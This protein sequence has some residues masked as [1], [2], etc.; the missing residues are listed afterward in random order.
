MLSYQ[1]NLT[2]NTLV[3]GLGRSGLASLDYYSELKK[4]G[5]NDV[6][7]FAYD[8]SFAKDEHKFNDLVASYPRIKLIKNK[9]EIPF[10]A[11]DECVASPGI[12]DEHSVITRFVD[13]EKPV[14]CDIEI[15]ARANTL[16]VVA[17]T[18]TNGKS[19]VVSWLADVLNR[20]GYKT[21]LAGNIGNPILSNYSF[22]Q[23]SKFDYVVLELSSF[24]L[25]RTQSL[26]NHVALIL[27]ITPDHMDRY[28]SIDD[29]KAAKEEIYSN[30]KC[31]V[32]N[33]DAED[34]STPKF[35]E[36][37]IN[38]S[39]D[40]EADFSSESINEEVY[41]LRGDQKL[42][43]Q[44]ALQLVGKHNL[45]NALAVLACCTALGIDAIDAARELVHFR[46]LPHRVE[47]LGRYKG[48]H[49]I[50]DSKATN[51]DATIAALSGLDGPIVLILGG[52]A[53]A[54]DL[55][56]L[57]KS[58]QAK[59]KKVIAYGKD[60]HRFVSL[61][62]H[63]VSVTEVNAF[64]DAVELATESAAKDDTVLL[65]PACSSLD[66]FKNYE[67]RGEEFRRLVGQLGVA[68]A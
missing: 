8:D 22:D 58:V 24:Q 56:G 64:I 51:A 27:N 6:N 54:A 52:D 42:V 53:K 2:N 16:P 68:N 59:V 19:T 36:S 65:S 46:G 50:N 33:K 12:S 32:M 9:F 63:L 23:G 62:G 4:S 37:V 60:K 21:L 13:S 49:Y 48:V 1:D 47:Y 38:Y 41:L 28:A 25:E 11:I 34:V 55:S 14:V 44:N 39:V 18:G 30:A 5:D 31:I 17:V 43:S 15:F 10:Y 40:K 3:L 45:S 61:L 66:M 67:Q 35:F 29:Y 26:K 57:T 20:L 7:V